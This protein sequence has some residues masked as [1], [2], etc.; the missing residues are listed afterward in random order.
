M[1]VEIDFPVEIDP[2]ILVI[3]DNHGLIRATES[4]S[5]ELLQFAKYLGERVAME[6]AFECLEEILKD[7]NTPGKSLR[8]IKQIP[9]LR[10]DIFNVVD[11]AFSLAP[12]ARSGVDYVK[13][14]FTNLKC[15][16]SVMESEARFIQ[17]R[18]GKTL[19]WDY[20][21]TSDIM[22]SYCHTLISSGKTSRNGYRINFG[23]IV[24][25]SYGIELR[26]HGINKNRIEIP[27]VLKDIFMD[28]ICNAREYSRKGK[29]IQA[30]M[31]ET[32]KLVSIRV[33]DQGYG[34]LEKEIEQVVKYGVRGKNIPNYKESG[35]GCGLTKAYYFTDALN[36][37]MWIESEPKKGTE[38]VISIPKD[39]HERVPS[40]STIEWD[41]DEKVG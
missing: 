34:I 26:I 9:N 19:E 12:F 40:I 31:V 18:L 10:Y 39:L 37:R 36:G 11:L 25:G 14:C 1:L 32:E 3:M 28:L 5:V 35:D 17:D 21:D 15:L 4:F 20:F 24:S 2:Q 7:I 30:T 8:R 33:R 13:S 41:N 29:L 38:V 22:D 6:P 16:Y 23:G 27:Y